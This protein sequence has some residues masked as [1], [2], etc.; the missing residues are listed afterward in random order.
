MLEDWELDAHPDVLPG[1]AVCLGFS[2]ARTHRATRRVA[3]K[4]GCTTVAVGIASRGNYGQ[5][6]EEFLAAY[7]ISPHFAV[8]YNIGQA[9]IA[10]GQPAD[11]VAALE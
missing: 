6:L 10:L 9:H 5:A 7:R 3:K 11:A 4:R 1:S 8:L 2:S